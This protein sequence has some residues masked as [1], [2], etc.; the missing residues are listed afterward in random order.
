[1]IGNLANIIGT[2]VIILHVLRKIVNV[3]E[4]LFFELTEAMKLKCKRFIRQSLI[5]SWGKKNNHNRLKI[6]PT[7]SLNNN[8]E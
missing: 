3:S 8:N 6:L 2:I 5:F 4:A 7:N 1:M